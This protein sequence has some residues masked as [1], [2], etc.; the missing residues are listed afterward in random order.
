MILGN[1]EESTK[2]KNNK[3]LV[4]VK[5]ENKIRNIYVSPYTEVERRGQNRTDRSTKNKNKKN[6]S[7][8]MWWNE[9]DELGY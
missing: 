3:N 1:R 7:E 9:Q 4:P 8:R 2:K 6:R 5:V